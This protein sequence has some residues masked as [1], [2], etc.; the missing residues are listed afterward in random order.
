MPQ[1]FQKIQSNSLELQQLQ[2]NMQRAI[3]PL[4]KCLIIDGVL[5]KNVQLSA[6]A[7]QVPHN[8]Q[9]KINGWMIADINANQ[10]VW[11]TVDDERF[12]TLIASGA[13]TCSLWIY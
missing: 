13:V 6:T 3:D 11:K 5:V 12:L 4:I 1:P 10:N 8:L 7:T 2:S 9:R